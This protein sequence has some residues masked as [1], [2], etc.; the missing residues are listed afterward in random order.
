MPETG[1]L[2]MDGFI[3]LD[4]SSLIYK[5]I[6]KERVGHPVMAYIDD[7]EQ[8]T[9]LPWVTGVPKIIWSST[10]TGRNS[11]TVCECSI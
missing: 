6:Y 7:V 9:Q 8:D 4:L 5:H 3:N 1:S 11:S 2:G 10:V